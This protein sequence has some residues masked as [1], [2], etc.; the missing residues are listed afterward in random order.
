ME[1]PLA[2]ALHARYNRYLAI[3][4]MLLCG[5]AYVYTTAPTVSFWDC[6]EYIGAAHTLAIPHPP[7]NPLYVML[8]RV[9][10][11][12]LF[13][14][15]QVALRIN[16]IA[17]FSGAATVMFLYLIIVR[18]MVGWVGTPDNAGKRAT[19][20][21]AGFVGALWAGFGSTFWFSCVEAEVNVVSMLFVVSSTWLALKWSQSDD[22]GRDRLL[23]LVSYLVFLG[24]GVHMFS[25]VAIVPVGLFIILVD[26]N[27]TAD[28][29]LWVSAILL[30]SAMYSMS[31]FIYVAPFLVVMA[32]IY[33]F[34]DY[35]ESRAWN[36]GLFVV[37]ALV[38]GFIDF[39]ELSQNTVEFGDVVKNSLPFL[40][41]LALAIIEQMNDNQS[42]ARAF[43]DKWRF[44]FFISLFAVIGFSVHLYIPIRSALRPFIDENHPATWDAF[45]SYLERKQYGSESMV[46]RMFHRRGAWSKQL[47]IDS[48]MGFGGFHLTQFFHFGKSMVID[49]SVS[50]FQTH[51]KLGGLGALLVYLLPTGFMGFGWY[52]MWKKARNT[53]I[54]LISLVVLGTIGLVFYMNFAD[55]TRLERQD[56]QY[57][58]S[59][60][61]RAM[62]QGLSRSEAQARIPKPAPVHR[63]VRERDYFF[64]PGFMW[65]GLWIGVASG[66]LLHL[67]FMGR[68]PWM[69]SLAP[70]ALVLLC[71]SPALP[72]QQNLG[73]SSRRGDWVPYDY[74]YNLLMSCD[75]DGILFTNGDNDTFPLWCLQEAYGVRKDVRIVNLSLL[76]TKWY[77]LQLKHIE[78]KLAITYSDEEIHQMPHERNMFEKDTKAKLP[79]TGLPVVIPGAEKHPAMRVQD[80][81]IVHIVDANQW[82]KPVYL[83]VTVSSDN[84]MGLD[85]Y[86]KMEGLVNRVCPK[87]VPPEERID[88]EKTLYMLQNVYR[89]RSLGREDVNLSETTQKLLANYS[90]CYLYVAY[91]MRERLDAMKADVK[92]LGEQAADG[93]ASDSLRAALV[94]KS[95]EYETWLNTIVGKLDEC[96][97]LMPWDWRPRMVRH[98]MLI[99]HERNEEALARAREALLLNPGYGDY[100][101]MLAEALEATGKTDSATAVLES[102]LDLDPD[103]W[104]TYVTLAQNLA[105]RGSYDSAIGYIKRFQESHPGDQRAASLIAYFERER[106][107]KTQLADSQAG[108][109]AP[110]PAGGQ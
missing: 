24:I 31:L 45:M 37:A 36:I 75:K 107:A 69:R 81:M 89:F 6:G 51:G 9:F 19:V 93:Q 20:Y 27:K 62:S 16:L 23:V 79:K 47:G 55:G 29:R 90:A 14:V 12:L 100:R 59:A 4:V 105:K 82:K 61:S 13:F 8:G 17:A 87:P 21:V 76:N 52:Y 33:A 71:A 110:V 63:E 25:M 41:L 72:F 74:A 91:A 53:A 106:D 50:L 109:A 54:L 44:I 5:A 39:R 43:R 34:V 2:A 73:E 67:L 18:A 78:P 22:P 104:Y 84:Y 57:W 10:S 56:M 15:Q 3:L 42:Q 64:T 99:A 86:L 65:F 98:Q 88:V 38:R 49:R 94:E 77:I 92:S 40:I 83:A 68:Q 26:K 32:A 96:V 1:Q 70:I 48:N 103:P 7:G 30:F 108:T 28:W 80:K 102:V 60:V 101:K 95:N 11:M 66:C 46:F 35:K 97:A 58:Q 85:P